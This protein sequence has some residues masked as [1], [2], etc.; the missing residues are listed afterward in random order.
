MADVKV[1][2]K[3]SPAGPRWFVSKNPG[4][5]LE[6]VKQDYPKEGEPARPH[7]RIPFKS[8]TKSALHV[9]DGYLG[10][11]NK[12]GTDTNANKHYGV[13]FVMDPGPRPEGGYKD[14]KTIPVYVQQ[15]G[16][17]VE[18]EDWM[19]TA[20]EKER[21]RKI[22]DHIRGI[23]MYRHTPQDNQYRVT[24]RLVEMNWDPAEIRVHVE[25]MVIP[26]MNKPMSRPLAGAPA[27]QPSEAAREQ[28]AKGSTMV[29]RRV[30]PTT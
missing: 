27:E 12:L 21:D 14:D 11:R 19:R 23:Y 24:A 17:E 10:S 26:G 29:R 3:G 4:L 15:D 16:K 2:G 6:V 13:Y 1:I 28:V 8:E 30:V 9:G 18:M 25:S 22:I 5:V 20:D 7:V